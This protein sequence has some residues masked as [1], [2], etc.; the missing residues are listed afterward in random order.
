MVE[1]VGFKAI[2]EPLAHRKRMTA[3]RKKIL[4]VITKS[5]WGGAG[6]YVYDL[7]TRLPSADFDIAVAAGGDG[8]LFAR[9]E[10]AHIRTIPLSWLQRD[11]NPLKEFLAFISLIILFFRERPD[12]IHLNS[13]K[14][15]GVGGI[16]AAVVRVATLSNHPRVLF[17]V[18]GW[19][20]LEPRPFWQRWI[21]VTGSWLS[22]LFHD[23]II[24][25]STADYRSAE[26][27]IPARKLALVFNGIDAAPPLPRSD[28]RTLI[29]E[30][31]AS[32]LSL[33][34]VLIGAVAE[35]TRNKGIDTLVRAAAILSRTHE[36][37]TWRIIVLGEGEERSQLE[38]IISQA[39]LTDS[40]AL[41]G[42][43]PDADRIVSAFDIFVLP[44]YK[45]GLPYAIMEAMAAGVPVVAS[46]VGGVPDL[47]RDRMNGLL[48]P[49]GDPEALAH[50]LGELIHHPGT[51]RVL[52]DVSRQ[53]L[54]NE[55][56]IAAMLRQTIGLYTNA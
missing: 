16:A 44:S 32:P 24:L 19:A 38:K 43:F 35:L 42:F 7:A 51:R 56:G 55:F 5:V 15:G 40:F 28:A 30:R 48:V 53:R 1:R 31:I 25:V 39:G 10:A 20:F 45:E 37:N 49:P 46:R 29:E 23:R 9:L 50:A 6:R 41:A 27:F 34:T 26:R 11:I 2:R 8:P 12:I 36:A 21:I 14:I 54:R 52:A 47:I 3:P 17:T 18:H 22:S 4:F 33:N 13:S